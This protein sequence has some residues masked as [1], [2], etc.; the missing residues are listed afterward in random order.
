MVSEAKLIRAFRKVK[1]DVV[2]LQRQVI[3]LNQGQ[4]ELLDKAAQ[5]KTKRTK[6]PAAPKTVVVTKTARKKT[7]YVASKDGEKYHI[8]SCPFAK[9]IKRGHR[10]IYKSKVKALSDGY[11]PCSCV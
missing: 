10:V 11:K 8:R 7:E 5:A 9:N 3:E 2:K 1:S 4:K 6:K